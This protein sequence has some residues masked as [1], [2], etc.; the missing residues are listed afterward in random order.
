MPN[1]AQISTDIPAV[2]AGIILRL[3]RLKAPKLQMP[4]EGYALLHQAPA[5]PRKRK[6]QH[7]ARLKSMLVQVRQWQ[8]DQR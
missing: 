4:L 1:P 5:D 2:I 7:R 3:K 8:N 6:R